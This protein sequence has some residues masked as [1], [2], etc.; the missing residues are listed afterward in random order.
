MP[1]L[2]IR[3][4]PQDLAMALIILAALPTAL[5]VPSAPTQPP[6]SI[7]RSSSRREALKHG[8]LALATTA[9]AGAQRRGAG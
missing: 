3:R 8:L 5:L 4:A 7:G 9:V 1:V 6:P 2:K